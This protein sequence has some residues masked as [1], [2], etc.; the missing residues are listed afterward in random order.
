LL[1]DLRGKDA[2]VEVRDG[3]GVGLFGTHQWP[4]QF[5]AG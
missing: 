4:T 2:R 3:V 5:S 1:P